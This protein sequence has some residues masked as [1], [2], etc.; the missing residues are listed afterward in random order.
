LFTIP[1]N[2]I[3]PNLKRRIRQID[4]ESI[5]PLHSYKRTKIENRATY[6]VCK[7]GRVLDRPGKRIALGEITANQGRESIHYDSTTGYNHCK[8]HLCNSKTIGRRC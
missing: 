7:G 4:I 8:V 3:L 1:P 5:A 6:K 2:Y